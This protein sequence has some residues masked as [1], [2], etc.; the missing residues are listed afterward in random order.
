M[1]EIPEHLLKRSRE[2]MARAKAA[3]GEPVEEEPVAAEQPPATEAESAP[4]AAPAAAEAGAEAQAP[5]PAAES[6]PQPSEPE[7]PVGAGAGPL[8]EE[9]QIPV[10]VQT[11]GFEEAQGAYSADELAE[12]APGIKEVVSSK[13]PGWLVALF[14]ILPVVALLYM[15]QFSHGVQCG[16]AGSL[17]VGADGQLL[18]CDGKPLPSPGAAGQQKQGPD[19]AE[20][21]AQRCA[22][23]HGPNGEGGVGLPLN[24]NNGTTLLEDF[25]TAAAQVEFVTK[26]NQAFPQG[27][28]AKAKQPK[29]VMPAF[30]NTLSPEEIQAVVQFERSLAGEATSGGA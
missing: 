24:K 14:V 27:W 23:C 30:G 7:A 19:G 17:Q 16:Q 18:T 28:G 22:A 9:E 10:G 3:K 6:P 4:E 25:P 11:A 21:F 8:A 12:S 5:T 13:A 26:G 1:V 2:A 20:I 29:G 15:T